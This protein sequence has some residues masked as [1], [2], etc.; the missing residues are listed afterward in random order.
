MRRR[1]RSSF[2]S[3]EEA[4][5]PI[6]NFRDEGVWGCVLGMA[7]HRSFVSQFWQSTNIG[8]I[9]LWDEDGCKDNG[10]SFRGPVSGTDIQDDLLY[11]VVGFAV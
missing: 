6:L 1:R 11:F 8:D 2:I 9:S 3:P 10:G 7:V 5:I 4:N